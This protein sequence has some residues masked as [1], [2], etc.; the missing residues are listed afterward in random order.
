MLIDVFD[1]TVLILAHLEKIV[2]LADAFDWPFAVRAEASLDVFFCPEP[3]VKRAVPS[4]I[5]ILVNQL[6]VDK[7]LQDI[8]ERLICVGYPSF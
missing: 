3:L 5:V 2:V 8:V 1:Q 4:S 6:F 7:V